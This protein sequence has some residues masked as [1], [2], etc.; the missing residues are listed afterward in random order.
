[1]DKAALL[2]LASRV[3]ALK[4]SCP[5]LG[6][7]VLKAL[8]RRSADDIGLPLNSECPTASIDAAMTLVP[9]GCEIGVSIFRKGVGA[10]SVCDKKGRQHNCLKAATPA[11][12]LC[13]AAL[14]AQANGGGYE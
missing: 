4:G 3:E 5:Y 8:G 11:L 2:A 1:M 6:L 13:A 12:A 10:A 7:D 14:R 9:E